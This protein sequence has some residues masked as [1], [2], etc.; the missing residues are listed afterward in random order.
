MGYPQPIDE[1]V[2]LDEQKRT[3]P[4]DDL[5]GGRRARGAARAP[6][7]RPRDPRR[8][9]GQRLHRPARQRDPEPPGRLPRGLA[10]RLDRAVP[11]EPGPGRPAR[12]RLRHPGRRQD[13][14]RAGPRPP[15]DH[16][17]QLDDPRH[18]GRPG[19]PRAARD[20][21]GRAGPGARRRPAHD[22][23]DRAGDRRARGAAL[24]GRRTRCDPADRAM[25]RR[26]EY[27][28]LALVL[29]VAAFSTGLPF[30]FYLLYLAILVVGGSYVLT[31]LGLADLEAGLRR[32]PAPGPRRRAAPGDLHPAQ[33][34]PAPE[35]LARG[36]QPDQPAGG[37]PRPGDLAGS[38]GRAELGGQGPA[39]PARPLPDRAAPGPDRRPV[40]VLRGL[41]D[42][43][44]GGDA[45]GL[46]AGRAAA[47]VA[48]ARRRTSRA[49][50]RRPSG[51]SR[52]ARWRR[53]SGRTRR[54]TA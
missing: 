19:G 25:I 1:I 15:P 22:R 10:A 26:I 13:P 51:R 32:G 20:A 3:H 30:L 50:T 16:Q 23:R 17:D 4:L 46:P 9:G 35:A 28:V 48:P 49:A 36:L 47:A 24:I 44:P 7:G 37:H 14:G 42:G 31:R 53:P 33:R 11:G 29:V 52:R 40:R 38:P 5:A 6:G 39:H 2:I 18:P 21:P 41:G 8:V 45:G 54:A 34:R 43:R 12:P 27:L